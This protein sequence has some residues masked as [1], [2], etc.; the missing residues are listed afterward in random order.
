M[1][2]TAIFEYLMVFL[3]AGAL[4]VT[5]PFF[6]AQTTPTVIRVMSSV[7]IAGALTF[8]VH[9]K[10]GPVPTS[11]YGLVAASLN[12]VLAGI[13]IGL[14]MSMA[15]QLAQIA[16]AMMDLQ[17]GLA[18]SQV[19]NPVGG[20]SVTVLSQFKFMLGLVIFLL[21]N[22]HHLVL[23]AFVKSYDAMPVL[24]M[25]SLPAIESG[26]IRVVGSMFIIALQIAAPILAVSLLLDG[27]FGLINRAVPQIQIYQL[28]LP[29]KIGVGLV[30]ISIGLPALTF[31]VSAGVNEGLTSLAPIFS[32]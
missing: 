15:L 3:R 21:S 30:V 16:G 31:A 12:E 26:L 8:A 1:S 29:A 23:H 14:F 24:G 22:A 9:E 13:L 7:S 2:E 17:V 27:A 25:S 32:R 4:L 18:S 19:L 6:G 5:S 20:I 10:V 28:A 11:M